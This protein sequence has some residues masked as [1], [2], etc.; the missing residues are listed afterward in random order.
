MPETVRILAI[1]PGSTSTKIAVFED[2]DRVYSLEITHEAEKLSEFNLIS[3]QFDYRK[4]MIISALA[5]EGYDFKEFTAFVGRGGGVNP[6]SGGTYTV[7]ELMLEH[8]RSR[9]VHPATLGPVLAHN[10]AM[11]NGKQAFIVNPPDVDEMEPVARV[12]GI[13]ALPRSSSFHALSHKEVG[14]RAA[15]KMGKSYRDVNL[16]VAHIGG[17]ISVAAHKKGRVVDADNLLY[18]EAPMAP[19]RAGVIPPSKI[20]SLCFSGEYTE[21]ELKEL[22][23]KNGGLI[24]HLGTSEVLKVK[25]RISRGDR[26]AELVYNAMIYQVA[27]S[28]GGFA[29]VLHGNVDAVVLTGGISRDEYFIETL[30][31]MVEFIAPVDVYP[32]ELE[33]EALASGALRVI[34]GEEKPLEYT[35]DPVWEGFE[36]FKAS[37]EKK[38]LKHRG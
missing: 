20:I 33:M 4:N 32:G 25:E 5:E 27:K 2:E 35:G 34:R 18:G 12:S 23:M 9:P 24:S 10:F 22:F 19:T 7:N 26:Y 1:N 3:D 16:V 8:V 6:C 29:A 38:E 21:K 13:A 11:A 36:S 17:G 15:E 14:I 30:T 37:N 28:I 31:K